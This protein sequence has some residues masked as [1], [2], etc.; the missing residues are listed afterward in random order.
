MKA[1]PVS[2]IVPLHNGRRFIRQAIA[3]IEAQTLQPREIL[4]IDD[5]S[6]DDGVALLA[7][8]PGLT[9]LRQGNAGEAAARNRGIAAA[10]QPLIAFLDQDD[11]WLPQK[12]ALQVALLDRDASIDIVY[13]LHRLIVDDDANWLRR[14][15]LDQPLRARLPGTLLARRSAFDRVGLF[16]E[17]LKLGSDVDWTWRANDAGLRF[18]P[19]NE[20]VLLRR[21]H[22]AN[23]S[24][25]MAQFADGLLVA[26]RASLRRKRG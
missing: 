25:N 8:I 22:R 3:S 6:E 23:A 24:R 20:E 26:A 19:L 14:D 17:D 13:G 21:I 18:Q 2:V 5:G 11:L 10:A 1:A 9:I 4:V 7:G 15:L 16:R 12:L